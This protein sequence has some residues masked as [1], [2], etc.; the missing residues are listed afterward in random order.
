MKHLVIGLIALGSFSTFAMNCTKADKAIR[1][2]EQ[3]L[4]VLSSSGKISDNDLRTV[5]L[6][7]VGVNFRVDNELV[8][9]TG[10]LSDAK[11]IGATLEALAR[12]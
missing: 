11:A 2:V 4:G 8:T 5:V 7:M 6:S 1:D 10:Y 12:P 3:R 9:C